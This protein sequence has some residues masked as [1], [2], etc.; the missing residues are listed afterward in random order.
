[1]ELTPYATLEGC[2]AIDRQTTQTTALSGEILMENAGHEM[3]RRLLKHFPHTPRFFILCGTGHNGGDGLVLARYLVKHNRRVVVGIWERALSSKRA[4]SPK[5][6]L[7]STTFGDRGRASSPPKHNR[8]PAELF[9]LNLERLHAVGD[10]G[11]ED[12]RVQVCRGREWKHFAP[13]KTIP[14]W[15]DALFGT[16]LNR[17]LDDEVGNLI[18]QINALPVKRVALDVPSGLPRCWQGSEVFRAHLTLTVGL[19]KDILLGPWFREWIGTL[20]VVPIDFPR[21]IVKEHARYLQGY[22]KVRPDKGEVSHK[23]SEG[24]SLILAGSSKYPGAAILASRAAVGNGAGY[25]YLGSPVGGAPP[26]PEIVPLA[27]LPPLEGEG[28]ARDRS[29]SPKYFDLWREGIEAAK[30]LLI[31]PGLGRLEETTDFFEAF[32]SVT[33]RNIIIDA[34]GLWHIKKYLHTKKWQHFTGNNKVLLTPHLGEFAQLL[35]VTADET[36][37]DFFVHLE[38]AR[39]WG[40][41]LLVKDAYLFYWGE[42]CY[43]FPF[44][45]RYLAKAG[46]GDVLAGFILGSLSLYR[47]FETAVVQGILRYIKKGRR[48]RKRFGVNGPIS[49][50]VGTLGD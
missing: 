50:M 28:V 47:S 22:G 23:A 40:C 49:L 11:G 36:K 43:Y 17:V 9:A 12:S 29:L 7:P 1:M 37:R 45:N 33:G 30:H 5:R 15:V 21:E 13:F 25:L 18:A 31:G 20:E 8:A 38:G 14:V 42:A 24:K 10:E 44:P 3:G 19:L 48:M 39:E 26:L 46:S 34:D 41:K 6:A 32:F 16:G 27:S 2:Q 35:G 4:L